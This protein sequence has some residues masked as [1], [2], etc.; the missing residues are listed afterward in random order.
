MKGLAAHPNIEMN[1]SI[2]RAN[3]RSSFFILLR[4]LNSADT[5]PNDSAV[6]RTSHPRFKIL[7]LFIVFLILFLKTVR[8]S[9]VVVASPAA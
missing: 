7:N 5:P 4:C 1:Y 6:T 2:R 9:K 3:S 8:G